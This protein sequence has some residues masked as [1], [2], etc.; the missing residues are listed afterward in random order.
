[1]TSDTIKETAIRL[2]VASQLKDA[3]AA[4]SAIM[5]AI[6]F[7]KAHSE[8]RRACDTAYE[9]ARAHE[10]AWRGKLPDEELTSSLRAIFR[11]KLAEWGGL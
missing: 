10:K 8:Y 4:R 11:D 1:M 5:Q 6:V 7:D 9:A 3:A 2:F